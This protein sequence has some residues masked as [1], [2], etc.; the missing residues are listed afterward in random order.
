MFVFW[1]F[2][3]L[4]YQLQDS[5]LSALTDHCMCLCIKTRRTDTPKLPPHL[6]TSLH[7][8]KRMIPMLSV[9]LQTHLE[10]RALPGQKRDIPHQH[11]ATFPL[12]RPT[13]IRA[14]HAWPQDHSSGQQLMSN[15]NPPNRPVLS[16]HLCQARQVPSPLQHQHLQGCGSPLPPS[17]WRSCPTSCSC[18]LPTLHLRRVACTREWEGQWSETSS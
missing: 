13:T 8:P 6:Q 11:Y 1:V 5:Q 3:W 18:L 14:P 16:S 12:W 10:G 7:A 2:V 9:P 4:F 15:A 17:P